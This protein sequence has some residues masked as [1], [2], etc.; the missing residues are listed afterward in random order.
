MCEAFPWSDRRRWATIDG[1]APRPLTVAITVASLIWLP[2][3]A[4]SAAPPDGQGGQSKGNKHAPCGRISKIDVPGAE[5]QVASCLDDLTTTGL[6]AHGT[7]YT[8][9]A[10][11]ASLHAPGTEQPGGTVPGIQVDGYFPDTSHFNAQHGWDHDAQFVIRLPDAWN[12]GLVVSG[13]PGTRTQYANDFLFSDDVLAQGYAFASTDKGN[14]GLNFYLD[15]GSPG[16]AVAEGNDRFYELTVAAK[17]VLKQRYTKRPSRTYAMGVSNGGYLVRHALENHPEE[18]DGGVDWAGV[19][20]SREHNAMTYLPAALQHY[21]VYSD[22][23]AA[24]QDR[25]AAYAALLAAG[26]EPGSEYLWPY[27]YH[28]AL[29]PISEDSDVYDRMVDAA[30]KGTC[31]GTTGSSGASTSTVSS[32]SSRRPVRCCPA[33]GRRSRRSRRGRLTASNRRRTPPWP[34]RRTSMW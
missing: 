24:P 15:G 2:V 25:E 7:T 19:I 1:M 3:W 6:L 33:P 12:G 30:G 23:D 29:L 20:Y 21:P 9:P 4:A 18:Y 22:P 14:S 34:G 10:D 5:H 11:W 31:T 32:R 13:A 8:D 26:L 28:D 16:D 27:H 17:E